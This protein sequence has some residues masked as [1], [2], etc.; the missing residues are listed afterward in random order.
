MQKEYEQN[1][2]CRYC[3]DRMQVSEAVASQPKLILSIAST[4]YKLAAVPQAMMMFWTR[5]AGRE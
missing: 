2:H 4:K 3:S 5:L 1:E